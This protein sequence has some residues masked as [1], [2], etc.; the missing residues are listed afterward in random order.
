MIPP[1]KYSANTECQLGVNN[2][3]DRNLP[4][5]AVSAAAIAWSC[6]RRFGHDFLP[7]TAAHQH[8]LPMQGLIKE[9]GIVEQHESD[10]EDKPLTAEQQQQQHQ[11]GPPLPG[12]SAPTTAEEREAAAAAAANLAAATPEVT[13][14]CCF[15]QLCAG[16]IHAGWLPISMTVF[17]FA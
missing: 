6:A 12:Q 1:S 14:Q 15:L 4:Q 3:L 8:L 17:V 7:T 16:L 11:Q 10:D 2:A 13:L 9:Y 5:A